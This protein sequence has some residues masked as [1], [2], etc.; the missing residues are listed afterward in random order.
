MAEIGIVLLFFFV[1]L[2]IN[3]KDFKKNI[4]ESALVTLF[5]SLLPLLFGFLI[6][7][8]I[9]GFDVITSLIIGVVLSATSQVI[10]INLLDELGYLK[11]KIGNH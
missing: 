2:N 10:S 5:K 9:F 6:S 7:K 11:T 3:L 4:K 1:G 8:F